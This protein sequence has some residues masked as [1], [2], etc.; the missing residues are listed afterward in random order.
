M[1]VPINAA[2]REVVRLTSANEDLDEQI[3]ILTEKRASNC[4]TAES[5][6]AIAEWEIVE[7]EPEP[8]AE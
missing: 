3:R 8:P 4:E 6:E 7:E 2:A 5:F 1:R